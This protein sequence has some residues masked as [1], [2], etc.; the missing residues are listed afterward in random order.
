MAEADAGIKQGRRLEH[1]YRRAMS[2]LLEV[3]DLRE[4]TAKRELY[5]RFDHLG[6]LL[7]QIG[8]RIWYAA[9]K[10]S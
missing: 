8:D 7:S 2:A 10:E 9:V 5:R 3:E 1:T 4:V 6:E